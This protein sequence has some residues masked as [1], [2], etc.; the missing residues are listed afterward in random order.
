MNFRASVT[1]RIKSARSALM[2]RVYFFFFFNRKMEFSINIF[3][4]FTLTPPH[5]SDKNIRLSVFKC[6]LPSDTG[7]NADSNKYYFPK[8]VYIPVLRSPRFVFNY[9]LKFRNSHSGRLNT[10]R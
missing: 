2:S 1:V 8:F 4:I 7:F 3:Y 6:P 9:S 10:E 5:D